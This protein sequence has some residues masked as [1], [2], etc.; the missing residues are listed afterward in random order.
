MS[1]SPSNA[2]AFEARR[3]IL[4]YLRRRWSGEP[5]DAQVEG[6][7]LST[8][9][10]TT[11]DLAEIVAAQI[12]DQELEE[13]KVLEFLSRQS[14]AEKQLSTLV[15]RVRK[16]A[17][18]FNESERATL[19]QNDIV[20]RAGEVTPWPSNLNRVGA[21]VAFCQNI[22]RGCATRA[23]EAPAG[24]AP[25]DSKR[26]LCERY[27]QMLR[28]EGFVP[29]TDRD[30]DVRFKYEGGTYLI[31]VDESDPTYVRLVYPNFW[32]IE[33]PEERTQALA[34]AQTSTAKTKS[35]KVYVVTDNVWASIEAFYPTPETFRGVLL[36]SLQALKAG[37]G[38]FV[39]A[40]R[41]GASS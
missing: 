14:P 16:L 38:T 37:V 20:G 13:S 11:L 3:Q 15:A 6:R 2:D 18:Q 4:D 30:G 10:L 1:A 27:L 40:M 7:P 41:G 29:D 19:L 8:Q 33:S 39:E 32:A 35:T 21:L 9:N 31:I 34:A 22:E 17:N 25:S 23:P 12:T 26:A 24:G 36:R 28:E 5:G